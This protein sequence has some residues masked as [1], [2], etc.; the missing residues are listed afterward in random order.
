M[1]SVLQRSLQQK[2]C[3][4]ANTCKG[5]LLT[6]CRD[7]EAVQRIERWEAIWQSAE[8][9]TIGAT[10]AAVARFNAL[11]SRACQLGAG[12]RCAS[13]WGAHAP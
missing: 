3:G 4:P 1:S 13:W 6:G 7:A 2:P 5:N 12:L 11:V 9:H 10:A 8:G